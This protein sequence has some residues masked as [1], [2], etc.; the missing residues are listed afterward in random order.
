M[1][2]LQCTTET[3]NQ[4]LILPYLVNKRNIIRKPTHFLMESRMAL[5]TAYFVLI[6]CLYVFIWCLSGRGKCD[7]DD[8][9][10]I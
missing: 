3:F 5:N 7:Y 1:H 4:D 9:N 10:P 8:Y 6:K 2:H